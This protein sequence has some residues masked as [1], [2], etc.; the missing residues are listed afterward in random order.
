MT[1][2]GILRRLELDDHQATVFATR[3]DLAGIE[4]LDLAHLEAR[5]GQCR[6]LHVWMPA[7]AAKL[8]DE[9][10]EIY[11]NTKEPAHVHAPRGQEF[12]E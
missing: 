9:G 3:L 4:R 8:Q 10:W 1:C 6:R 12:D 11:V 2:D 7:M 5:C